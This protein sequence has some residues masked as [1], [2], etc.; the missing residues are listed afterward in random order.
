MLAWLIRGGDREPRTAQISPESLTASDLFRSIFRKRPRA[1]LIIL[2]TTQLSQT[3]S[4]VEV[5]DEVTG[6]AYSKV[7]VGLGHVSSGTAWQTSAMGPQ[8]LV[9]VTL[10]R[11]R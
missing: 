8:W 9:A 2:S 1:R 10:V 5:I 3:G 11:V 4:A 7:F 6:S